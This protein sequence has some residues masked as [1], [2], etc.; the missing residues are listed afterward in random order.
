MSPQR[1]VLLSFV[2]TIA[3]ADGLDD[4][5][6]LAAWRATVAAAKDLTRQWEGGA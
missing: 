5:L 6:A 4:D 2:R 1:Y 3:D